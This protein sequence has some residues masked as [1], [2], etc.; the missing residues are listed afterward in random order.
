[1]STWRCGSFKDWRRGNGVFVSRVTE[2][3]WLLF[4]L[5][6]RLRFAFVTAATGARRVYIGPLE[7]ERYATRKDTP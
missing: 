2:R 1:M 7:I 6:P 4:A 3:G 5:R